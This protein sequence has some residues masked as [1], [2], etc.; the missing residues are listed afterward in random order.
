MRE[1]KLGQGINGYSRIYIV[2]GPHHLSTGGLLPSYFWREINSV[3]NQQKLKRKSPINKQNK[4]TQIKTKQTKKTKPAHPA[5]PK[6]GKNWM[7]KSLNFSEVFNQD[8]HFCQDVVRKEA[9]NFHFSYY[10]QKSLKITPA[11]QFLG[12]LLFL[13]FF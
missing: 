3:R 13:Q 11:F 9:L 8:Q 5:L 12:F 4:V 7:L 10:T 6:R 2:K 1:V